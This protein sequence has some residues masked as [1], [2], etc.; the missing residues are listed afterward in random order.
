MPDKVKVKLRV[1]RSGPGG[2]H[3]SGDI[4]EV[5]KAESYRLIM[6]DQAVY[7]DVAPTAASVPPQVETAM[8]DTGKP[9]K[10]VRTRRRKV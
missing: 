10:R 3:Q 7:V 9:R 4:I 8:L 1:C 6:D 5:G 2:V